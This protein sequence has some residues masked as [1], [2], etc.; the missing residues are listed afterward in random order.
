LYLRDSFI[1]VVF[2]AFLLTATL[3][4]IGSSWTCHRFA[5]P[6]HRKATPLNCRTFI[7]IIMA[8][9]FLTVVFGRSRLICSHPSVLCSSLHLQK[10]AAPFD[11]IKF[12]DTISFSIQFDLKPRSIAQLFFVV[13]LPFRSDRTISTSYLSDELDQTCL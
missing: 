7:F 8:T 4:L 11:S 2:I 6:K 12:F 10:F 5:F 3:R 9:S 13:A 1:V